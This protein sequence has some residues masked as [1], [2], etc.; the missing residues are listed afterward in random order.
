[1]SAVP[2]AC[3]GGHARSGLEAAAFLMEALEI[4]ACGAVDEEDEGLRTFGDEV[5]S[6]V[7]RGDTDVKER[8]GKPDL[9]FDGGKVALL[10]GSDRGG[11]GID[12]VEA[13]VE[14]AG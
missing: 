4:I 13:V 12:A 9:I 1:M 2:V 3:G 10:V 8:V 14:V 6:A 5:E 11:D 7:I